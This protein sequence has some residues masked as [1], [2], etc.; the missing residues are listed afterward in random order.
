M[1]HC[2]FALAFS[3]LAAMA[4]VGCSSAS[5][6]VQE[7]LLGR[8]KRDIL[9]ARVEDAREEQLEAKEQF[10]STFEQF[11]QL[12]GFDGGELEKRYQRLADEY[13]E[14]E[15]SAESVRERVA[16]IEKVASDLFSEWERENQEIS[17]AGDRRASAD[18]LDD[19]KDRY[20]QLITAM[21]KASKGMDPVLR[22]FKDKVLLLKH[23]LNAQAIASLSNQVVSIQGDVDRLVETMQKSI[24]EADAFIGSMRPNG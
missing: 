11:K 22:A 6:A 10:L 1:N 21:K 20:K 8:Q 17:N 12:T 24:A 19:T 18:L 13:D 14:C 9:V 7:K 15:D 3:F 5:Y 16:S 2:T 23:N 4:L